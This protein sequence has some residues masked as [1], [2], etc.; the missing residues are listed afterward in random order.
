VPCRQSVT[1]YEA[2]QAAGVES[3]LVT[4]PGGEHGFDARMEDPAV[5]AALERAGDFLDRHVR[6]G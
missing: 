3:E 6:A 5:L 1:M 2:L 4:I